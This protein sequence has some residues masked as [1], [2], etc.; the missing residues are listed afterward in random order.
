MKDVE[1]NKKERS[2][3]GKLIAPV[4]EW[5]GRHPYIATILAFGTG[6]A[7]GTNAVYEG[8]R[9]FSEGF[10]EREKGWAECAQLEYAGD[11]CSPEQKKAAEVI[12]RDADIAVFAGGVP[13]SLA[14]SGTTV[15][16]LRK[17][18]KKET[19]AAA[20]PV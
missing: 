9:L 2:A 16:V 6:L 15:F 8:T 4:I 10:D 14:F 19:T 1:S 13:L 3:V 17:K 5:M 11:T 7:A 18:R 12:R 20:K